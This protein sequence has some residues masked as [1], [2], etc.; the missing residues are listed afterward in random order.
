MFMQAWG[1]YG[2]A[3]SVVHQ[4]LGVRPSLGHGWLEV[5]PQV[6][7]GH[8]SVKGSGI[9]LGSGA[10]DVTAT[11]EGARYTTTTATGSVPISKFWIGHTLPHGSAVAA[12][13]LDGKPVKDYEKRETN[14]GLEV[15]VAASP[16]GRHTLVVTAG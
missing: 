6:P 12:V 16:H 13:A 8:T 10:A 3:W 4:Q 11:H 15:R 1:H 5:V 14:R 7:E 9:R 2:T